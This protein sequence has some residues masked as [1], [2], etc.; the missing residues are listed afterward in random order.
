MPY[1]FPF[2][3]VEYYC[4]FGV[5]KDTI[6][7][8][9]KIVALLFLQNIFIIRCCS[10]TFLFIKI[11]LNLNLLLIFCLFVLILYVPSAI[12]QLNRDGSSSV[13]AVLS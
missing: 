8:F 1:F 7:D 13:E 5:Y 3:T 2:S 6:I 12:F 10:K 11:V 9:C 4:F